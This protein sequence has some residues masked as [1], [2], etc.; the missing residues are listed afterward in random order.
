MKVTV[1]RIYVTEGQHVYE[2]IFKRLHD[3][4]KV[5]GVT[6]FRGISGF[7]RSGEM[8][9]SVLLDVSFDLPVVIEFFDEDEKVQSVIHSLKDIVPQCHILTFDAK[10]T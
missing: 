4:H 9:S 1:A 2:K 7:G 6:V 10:L 5:N 3:E 8:H